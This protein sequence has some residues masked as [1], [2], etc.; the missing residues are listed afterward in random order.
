MKNALLCLLTILAT[1]FVTA[2]DA[3]TRL[4]VDMPPNTEITYISGGGFLPSFFRI[5]IAGDTMK[6]TDQSPKTGQKEIVW[7]AKLSDD[8]VKTLYRAF[9]ENRFDSIEPNKEVVVPDGKFRSME[10]KF[11]PQRF[12]AVMGD[13]IKAAKSHADRFHNIENVLGA[14]IKKYR[15]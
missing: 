2:C 5:V 1:S 10:L 12:Y 3:Q 4:P 15:K 11:G 9:V 7:A 6:V 8:E 14:L 13:G